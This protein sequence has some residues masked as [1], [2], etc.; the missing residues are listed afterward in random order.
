MHIIVIV[1]NNKLLL[2]Q[3]GFEYIYS[4]W[5]PTEKNQLINKFYNSLGFKN[6]TNKKAKININDILIRKYHI[7]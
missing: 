1:V 5:I 7:K 2:N 4:E 6:F 3:Q